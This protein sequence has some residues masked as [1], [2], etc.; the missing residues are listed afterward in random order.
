M[1]KQRFKKR[2]K[3]FLVAGLL[4]IWATIRFN[5]LQIY[6]ENEDN[7]SALLKTFILDHIIWWYLAPFVYGIIG[8]ITICV[9]LFK[10]E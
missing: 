6:I 10:P 1:N 7:V 2:M 3:W 9:G 4:L 8:L 5:L